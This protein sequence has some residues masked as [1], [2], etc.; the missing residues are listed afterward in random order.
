MPPEGT[1]VTPENLSRTQILANC[2]P[3]ASYELLFDS[4]V[5]S[6]RNGL[7]GAVISARQ[8]LFRI[9]AVF[10]DIEV[11]SEAN[12]DRCSLIGQ[13]LDSSNPGQR[14][15]GV[16]IS[17]LRRG[18]NVVRT[19]SNENGEFQLQFVSKSDLELSVEVDHGCPVYLRISQPS[20]RANLVPSR[21]KRPAS[22]TIGRAAGA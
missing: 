9:G 5:Q 2:H 17:L 10:V 14:L 20:T 4:L 19:S 8:L 22:R 11:G 3:E 13:M 18:R 15:A 7:R 12:S 21:A 16:P 6:P 1:L